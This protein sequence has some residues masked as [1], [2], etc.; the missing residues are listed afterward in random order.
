[1]LYILKAKLG[2]NELKSF[3]DKNINNL[4]DSN[5]KCFVF[6]PNCWKPI[7]RRMSFV[8]LL[9][10]LDLDNDSY[11][12]KMSYNLRHLFHFTLILFEHK[13]IFLKIIFSPSRMDFQ[14]QNLNLGH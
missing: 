7:I 9:R 13:K 10:V 8:V 4:Y 1:M 3:T 14:E 11:N 5:L 6:M 12:N 2:R